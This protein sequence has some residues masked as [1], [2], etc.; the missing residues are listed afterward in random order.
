VQKIKVKK[1]LQRFF[2]FDQCS[3]FPDSILMVGQFRVL[4]VCITFRHMNIYPANLL[5]TIKG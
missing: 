5:S 3:I 1:P 2:C 4:S